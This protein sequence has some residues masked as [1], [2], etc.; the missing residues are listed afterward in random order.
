MTNVKFAVCSQC[1]NE[2]KE[3]ELIAFLPLD[4]NQ[5][6]VNPK[7]FGYCSNCEIEGLPGFA[8]LCFEKVEIEI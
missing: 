3:S 7:P 4:L 5:Y 1:K 8:P 2:F 6:R